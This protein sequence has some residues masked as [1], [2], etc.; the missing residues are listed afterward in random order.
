MLNITTDI[1]PLTDFKRRTAEFVEQLRET[2]RPM[3]LTINGKPEVV[4]LDAGVFQRMQE[5]LAS[6]ERNA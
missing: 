5:T 2:G 4:V 6:G 1:H 3:I